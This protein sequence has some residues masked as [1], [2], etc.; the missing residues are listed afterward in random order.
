MLRILFLAI[1]SKP[2]PYHLVS[3]VCGF[4][5]L[6]SPRNQDTT[7][8]PARSALLDQRLYGDDAFFIA[9]H[10]YADVLGNCTQIH[11][12][13]AFALLNTFLELV[14]ITGV[15]DGVGGWRAYGVD[16]SLFSRKLME[17]C[18]TLVRTGKFVP[19]NPVDLLA[20]GFEEMAENK[21]PLQ[22][23]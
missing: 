14:S 23:K 9:K 6:D 19:T 17:T 15:A 11:L 22:G 20:A 8:K 2:H 18:E 13:I 3:A 10:N 12:L 21:A 7:S 4:S 5:K 16:P 1:D